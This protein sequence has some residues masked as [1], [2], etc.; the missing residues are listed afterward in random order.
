[1]HYRVVGVPLPKLCVS[2]AC[3]PLAWFCCGRCFLFLSLLA[4]VYVKLLANA[5]VVTG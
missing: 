3:V 1:M 2:L 4:L 5:G